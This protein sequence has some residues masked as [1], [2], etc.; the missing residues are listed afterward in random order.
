MRKN[1]FRLGQNVP[2]SYLDAFET[3]LSAAAGVAPR[4]SLGEGDLAFEVQL[5]VEFGAVRDDLLLQARSALAA[6]VDMDDAVRTSNSDSEDDERLATLRVYEFFVELEYFATAVNSQWSEFFTA[7]G[8]GIWRH[9]G[10]T[11]PWMRDWRSGATPAIVAVDA[12]YA[13]DRSSAAAVYFA[14]WSGLHAQAKQGIAKEGA[15]PPYEPGAFYKRE[16]PLLMELLDQAL[17][18]VSTIVVDGYVWLSADGKPGLGARLYEALGRCVPVIGVAK[19]KFRDDTWSQ[20]V[21]RGASDAPLYI[22]SVGI[23]RADAARRMVNMSGEG[24]T[25]KLIS[26]ADRL[27]RSIVAS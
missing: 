25:P 22:T 15:P 26:Q 17:I 8:K 24:R 14:D 19:T 1:T 12:A 23:D 9:R 4:V 21:R 11:M 7:D 3:A 10:K 20:P 5:P 27:A 13:E 18:P 6:I 16:L 2:S